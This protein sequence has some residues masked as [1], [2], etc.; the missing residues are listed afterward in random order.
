[1]AERSIVDVF[2]VV[3]LS[4]FLRASFSC[5]ATWWNRRDHSNSSGAGVFCSLAG[6][7]WRLEA[8]VAGD[9]TIVVVVT[10]IVVVVEMR[11]ASI[12][13]CWKWIIRPPCVVGSAIAKQ[14]SA[15]RAIT[16]RADSS[17][18]FLKSLARAGYRER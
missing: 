1:M 5:S 2:L 18:V 10:V 6:A 8:P 11:K 15:N 17:G 12:C 7:R 9:N 3:D 13:V 14:A 16:R 4:G